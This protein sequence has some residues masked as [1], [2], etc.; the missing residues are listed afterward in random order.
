MALQ[1]CSM[2]D[3]ANVPLLNC[4]VDAACRAYHDIRQEAETAAAAQQALLAQETRTAADSE[5]HQQQ[6]Q[7]V[8]AATEQS[9]AASEVPGWHVS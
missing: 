4:S 8:A 1:F 3:N 9:L 2:D 5:H 7:K 6:Q